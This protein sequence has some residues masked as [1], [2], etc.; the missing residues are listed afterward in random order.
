M[1]DINIQCASKSDRLP[2]E[3]DITNW[4][5]AA[6]KD[7]REQAELSIRIV[8]EHES[9]ALNHE[10]RAKDKPT[11]VLSFPFEIPEGLE[12][13][14]DIA[15]ILGDLVICA[16]IVQ[17]EAVQQNKTEN[18]HWAH[19]VVH[20]C[21]HLLGFDHINDIDAEQMESRERHILAT[22]GFCDPYQVIE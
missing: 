19:M 16:P 15:N 4:V 5:T 7:L 14:P 3:S 2:S 18:A 8:D 12:D 1:I 21:L 13:E 9:Q 6:L 22:L 20:G 10:Y 11:N 17:Q